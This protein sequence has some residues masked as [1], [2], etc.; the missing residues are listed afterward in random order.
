MEKKMEIVNPNV[1]AFAWLASHAPA[2]AE[3][4]A[5]F[6]EVNVFLALAPGTEDPGPQRG[7]RLGPFARRRPA[8]FHRKSLAL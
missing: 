8:D 2:F 5:K 1:T 3:P 7:T 6:R 4:Y